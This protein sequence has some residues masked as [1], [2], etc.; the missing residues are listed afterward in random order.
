MSGT[1]VSTRSACGTQDQWKSLNK[2]E[3]V[4]EMGD[5]WSGWGLL[6]ARP[7]RWGSSVPLKS[8]INALQ[9][10]QIQDWRNRMQNIITESL[11]PIWFSPYLIH[12]NEIQS[13]TKSP[14]VYP[15]LCLWQMHRDE[16]VTLFAHKKE[17]DMYKENFRARWL[18]DRRSMWS[19]GSNREGLS[20]GEQDRDLIPDCS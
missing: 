15:I 7:W 9:S 5:S 18:N 8:F 3:A 14:N 1:E 19:W 16:W 17:T 6:L 2:E 13:P 11:N 4:Q 20:T 12:S 10:L